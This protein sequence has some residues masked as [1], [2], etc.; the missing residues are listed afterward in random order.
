MW[1]SSRSFWL[2]DSDIYAGGKAD[3]TGSPEI[4][5]LRR[6]RL[7]RRHHKQAAAI[8]RIRQHHR[9]RMQSPTPRVPPPQRR[10][11]RRH[12][13][14]ALIP[15][16]RQQLQVAAHRLQRR[17]T[18]P[19]RRP[20]PRLRSLRRPR[21]QLRKHHPIHTPAIHTQAIRIPALTLRHC[22]RC[23]RQTLTQKL[24]RRKQKRPSLDNLSP[25]RRSRSILS[26]RRNA[27]SMAA[28]RTRIAIVVCGC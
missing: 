4:R 26:P 15:A 8:P 12:H 10:R 13:N 6:L 24:D 9:L 21:P 14:P 18:L 27:I 28:V 5:I 25:H 23:H 19:R 16:V 20:T 1:F 2:W 11:D 22:L 3:S 17:R 7:Q